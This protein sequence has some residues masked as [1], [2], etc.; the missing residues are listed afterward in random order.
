MQLAGGGGV[1]ERTFPRLFDQEKVIRAQAVGDAER[2][3]RRGVARILWRC[4]ACASSIA[5]CDLSQELLPH[6]GRGVHF[7]APQEGIVARYQFA[8]ERAVAEHF[9]EDQRLGDVVVQVRLVG[10]LAHRLLEGGDGFVVFE[11]VEVL[12]A[13]LDQRVLGASGRAKSSKR[14]ESVTKTHGPEATPGWGLGRRTVSS[15]PLQ[16]PAGV[17]GHHGVGR[18]RHLL[19]RLAEFLQPR[20]PMAMATL[21][22]NPV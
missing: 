10:M 6:R 17:L 11:I 16:A 15:Q 9:A 8:F 12:I 1:V 21:R 7:G 4:R 14:A 18:L 13:A 20:L 2:V 5:F 19:Q 3:E 22:R